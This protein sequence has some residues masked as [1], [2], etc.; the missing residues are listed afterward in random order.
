MKFNNNDDLRNFSEILTTKM[1]SI[2]EMLLSIDLKNW[3]EDS[4]TTSSEFLGELKLILVRIKQLDTL[5]LST[6]QDVDDC[7]KAINRA[8]GI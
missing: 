1:E 6:K 8:F 3:S 5:D 2:G 4:F 7:I